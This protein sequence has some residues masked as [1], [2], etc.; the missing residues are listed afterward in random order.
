MSPVPNRQFPETRHILD[1]QTVKS[2]TFHQK[3]AYNSGKD[4]RFY[5]EKI[6]KALA[7][8]RNEQDLMV[9]PRIC[10]HRGEI[11]P[12]IYKLPLS[13]LTLVPAARASAPASKKQQQRQ[14]TLLWPD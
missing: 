13:Q 7:V 14:P 5:S 3:Q 8:T 12:R 11:H 9:Q 6:T 10:S 2:E 4:N 1:E